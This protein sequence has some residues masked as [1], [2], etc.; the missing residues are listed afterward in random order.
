MGR[1]VAVTKIL[2]HYRLKNS[3][4]DFVGFQG[5]QVD[6]RLTRGDCRTAAETQSI[7]SSNLYCGKITYKHAQSEYHSTT[8]IIPDRFFDV[9]M[10][11]KI[12][13]YTFLFFAIHIQSELFFNDAWILVTCLQSTQ[14]DFSS[15]LGYLDSK[16]SR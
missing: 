6:G 5:F 16:R 1:L 10:Y 4:V 9:E 7:T 14:Y 11:L 13:N 8:W 12:R 15:V 2:W 3:D